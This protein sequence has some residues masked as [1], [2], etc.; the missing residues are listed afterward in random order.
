[1]M[2][3][4]LLR[5]RWLMGEHVAAKGG[6]P[7]PESDAPADVALS[8]TAHL[9][10]ATLT[11]SQ[12]HFTCK[13]DTCRQDAPLATAWP[14]EEGEGELQ[15]CSCCAIHSPASVIGLCP[16]RR[17]SILLHILCHLASRSSPSPSFV[18]SSR[19]R[20]TSVSRYLQ[21]CSSPSPSSALSDI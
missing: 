1:M 14:A 19:Q 12:V 9:L 13:A 20:Q 21:R 15:G 10:S 16:P 11:F 4:D 3:I 17:F 8:T 18:L 5:R 2:V 6:H 7:L